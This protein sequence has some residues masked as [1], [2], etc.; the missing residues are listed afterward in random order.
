MF[1]LIREVPHRIEI[2]ITPPQLISMFP[3]ELQEHPTM[4]EIE[5]IWKSK[6][7]IFSV[8]TLEDCVVNVSNH[9]KHLKVCNEKMLEVLENLDRFEIILFYEG[10]EDKYIVEKID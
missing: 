2:T 4:G 6:D 7:K 9:R 1:R 5:R 3:I 10:T 8:S